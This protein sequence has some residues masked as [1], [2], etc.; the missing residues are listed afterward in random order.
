VEQNVYKSLQAGFCLL[1]SL[2]QRNLLVFINIESKNIS[3]QIGLNWRFYVWLNPVFTRWI[4][5]V[6]VGLF[7]CSHIAFKLILS[8]EYVF[9]VKRS[10]NSKQWHMI[11]S[12][13]RFFLTNQVWCS[14]FIQCLIHVELMKTQVNTHGASAIP[15]KFLPF[16]SL[17][18]LFL[19]LDYRS[20]KTCLGITIFDII[21]N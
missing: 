2:I 20:A 10:P 3:N 7:L 4:T 1:P 21:G 19:T 14:W 5:E 12:K 8:V 9:Q 11:E 6:H 18:V 13:Y 15:R 16:T 17:R